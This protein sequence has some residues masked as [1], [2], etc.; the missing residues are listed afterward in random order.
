MNICRIRVLLT[1][2]QLAPK[3]ATAVTY[4]CCLMHN[5]LIHKRPQAYLRDVAD[6][7]VPA[8]PRLDWQDAQTL[9]NLQVIGGNT[10]LKEGK[11]VRN[12]LRDYYNSVGAVPWQDVAVDR[13]VSYFPKNF[14]N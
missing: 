7:H 10:S 13:H 4:A 2:M 14:Q 1:C 5:L 12:H 8:A 11:V 6:N 9:L 3:N